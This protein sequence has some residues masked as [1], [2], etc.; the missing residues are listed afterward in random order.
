M[1]SLALLLLIFAAAVLAMCLI[2]GLRAR[3]SE[4]MLRERLVL[5][6][7][8]LNNMGHGLNMFDAAGRMVLSNDRY[9]EM[10]ALDP[11]V[12]RRGVTWR[13]LLGSPPAPSSGPA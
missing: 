5:L 6:D 2:A 4:T 3:R 1:N 7:C 12:V 10:Y 11:A 8:A 13:E 9:I